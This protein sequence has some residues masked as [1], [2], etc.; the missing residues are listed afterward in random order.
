MSG[1]ESFDTFG[2]LS[3][4][5]LYE[6]VDALMETERDDLAT[7]FLL[8][9]VDRDPSEAPAW[10]RLGHVYQSRLD[11]SKAKEAYL[12][13]ADADKDSIDGWVG[14]CLLY[15]DDG[16][17]RGA[18]RIYNRRL[19]G[20]KAFKRRWHAA[21]MSYDDIA[22]SME[23]ELAVLCA[24]AFKPRSIDVLLRLANI[25]LHIHEDLPTTRSIYQRVISKDPESLYA[26]LGLGDMYMTEY[27]LDMARAAFEKATEIAPSDSRPWLKLGIVQHY[28]DEY[29][30]AEKSYRTA[31]DLTPD[32]PAIMINLANTLELMGR[33]EEADELRHMSI[34]LI[35]SNGYEQA[36]R[37]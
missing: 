20:N 10:C 1:E 13:A 35:L 22:I 30:D 21:G 18:R 31:L 9:M 24:A 23:V 3:R 19:R 6:V 29:D 26:W 34:S 16:D 11:V 33:T 36:F 32:D 27:D 2:S 15:L 4:E 5:T 25:T 8:H 7:R 14:L 37:N 12:H 28:L 17:R